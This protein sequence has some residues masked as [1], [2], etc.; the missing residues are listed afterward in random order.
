[1]MR[2]TGHGKPHVARSLR[3]YLVKGQ[4]REKADNAGFDEHLSLNVRVVA[5]NFVVGKAI[6]VAADPL[7]LAIPYH[8]LDRLAIDTMVHNRAGFENRRG[9]E[10]FDE[11]LLLGPSSHVTKCIQ[12]FVS[13]NGL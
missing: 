2:R 5:V 10:S 11:T 4:R 1:M 12:L 13:V 3:S 6:E 9:L 8:A 7:N